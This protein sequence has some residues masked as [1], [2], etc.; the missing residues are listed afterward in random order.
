[1]RTLLLAGVLAGLFATQSAQAL[2][3]D[4]TPSTRNGHVGDLLTYELRVEEVGPNI[5][6]GFDVDIG[7]DPSVLNLA[8]F[9]FG[10]GLNLGDPL[11][12]LQQDWLYHPGKLN[13]SEATLLADADL[14][15]LP[16]QAHDFVLF[17]LTF[18]GLAAGSSTLTIDLR[19]MSGLSEPNSS[20]P[21][22]T[23]IPVPLN[24]DAVIGAS[25]TILPT[26]AG[27]PEPSILLLLGWGLLGMRLAWRQRAL[28]NGLAFHANA[29]ESDGDAERALRGSGHTPLTHN[30]FPM[31]G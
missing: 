2:R 27:V 13:L 11:A 1:M 3:L 6:T 10:S 20:C 25:A 17:S 15:A 7:Y 4:M 14:R 18:T 26:P 16:G 30:S 31:L 29:G 9:A 5:V 23:L 12:S 24:P 19:G 8:A 21:S 22:C 28:R